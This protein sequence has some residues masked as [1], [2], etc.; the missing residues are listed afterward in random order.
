MREISPHYKDFLILNTILNELSIG[1][2]SV[3]DLDTKKILSTM[4]NY[5]ASKQQE[6]FNQDEIQSLKTLVMICN[7]LYNRTDMLVLP[8][9]DG[10]Y[11]LLM[12]MYKKFDP[13]FQVGSYVVQFQ[14][15][16]DKAM[17][18]EGLLKPKQPL[19]FYEKEEKDDT[20]KYFEDQLKRF[21]LR[22]RLNSRDVF[23]KSPIFF[24]E[25]KYISKKTHDTKHNHPDLVGTLDKCKFVLDADAIEKDVYDKDNVSILERDFFID[26]IKRGIITEDQELELVLE[27]KYDG[28][29]VEADCNNIV[30]SARTRGDTGIGEASD[31][32]DIL[33]GYRFPRN[34]ALKDRTIG[35]KFEAIMTKSDL[36][37]FN[38][39]RGGNYKN[40]RTAIVGLFGASDAYKFRDFI[41]LIPLAVDRKD[42]P[43]IS[44][45]MEEIELLN[46]LFKTKGEPLRYCYIKGNY[47]TCL[48]LIKKF[49][50][51]AKFAREYLDFMFDGIVV[52]YLD[53]S[54]REKLGRENYINKYSMA[55]KFDPMEKLTTFL[56][57]TFEVGQAGN[58]CPMIHYSP[59]EFFGT[60]HPKST[61]SSLKRFNDLALKE[62]D[63]IAVT[64]TNDVMPYVTSIDCEHNRQN[65]NPLCQFP[66]ICPECGTKLEVS[67]SGNSAYC[68][69]INCKGRNLARMVNMLQ[70]L[71]IK[72]F[73]ES[74]IQSINKYHFHELINLKKEEE[75]LSKIIGPGNTSNLLE[76]INN[77]LTKPTEDY[78]LVGSLG[79]TNVAVQTWKLVFKKYTLPE[80]IEAMK[81][82]KLNG[83]NIVYETIVGI[84]NIGEAT[85]KTIVNEY[86]YFA[87]DLY[88]IVNNCNII[89]SKNIAT[90]K[91]IRF[92]GCRNKQLEEQLCNDG[93]DADGNASVTKQTDILIVPYEGFTSTKTSK[94]SE[95][96]MIIP[97]DEFIQNKDKYL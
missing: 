64:Y 20:R 95:N 74:T 51:E 1:N 66:T 31:I 43:E 16:V 54:I 32:T 61:G 71:N 2:I 40:C 50:E 9:E 11:D 88:A 7:I 49:A 29:S 48:F 45:R 28:I 94:V 41:T 47:K 87:E 10:V 63:I 19:V 80:F 5:L 70:K 46:T 12:E 78:R 77:L 23:Y 37:R 57:Y 8:V 96:T 18:A 97:I 26:H 33:K 60:I 3:L 35:V 30:E 53:E 42:V 81:A 72:G 84:K 79:F 44:N 13:N 17:E 6:E 86:D 15:S 82:D 24:E 89:S 68:P 85:A 69:N 67:K 59:V 93:F 58:I 22:D 38:V 4:A 55:V 90:K 14:A 65:P 73:A 62:G 25:D 21:D 39:A 27:L 76:S 34:T 36:Q 75:E 52:S 83:T 56:G 92:T 91:Q